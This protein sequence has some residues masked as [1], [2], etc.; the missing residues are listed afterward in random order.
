MFDVWF[1]KGMKAARDS[2]TL[3]EAIIA[4]GKLPKSEEKSFI[5]GYF[6]GRCQIGIERIQQALPSAKNDQLVKLGDELI[7]LSKR[8]HT[9]ERT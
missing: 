5:R 2:S 1:K 7:T 8:I 6:M 9:E 3:N 4:S